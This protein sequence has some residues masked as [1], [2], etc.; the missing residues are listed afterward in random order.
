MENAVFKVQAAVQTSDEPLT[1]QWQV[2]KDNGTTWT[3]IPLNDGT[4]ANDGSVGSDTCMLIVSTSIYDDGDQFR[5]IVSKELNGTPYEITSQAGTL[6]IG[7]VPGVPTG[8]IYGAHLSIVTHPADLL[9][10]EGATA[11]FSVL[12][13]SSTIPTYQW[14]VSVDNGITY[15]VIPGETG[16]EYTFTTAAGDSGNLYR[17]QVSLGDAS[18]FT[19]PAELTLFAPLWTITVKVDVDDVPATFTG[20]GGF[21]YP[22]GEITVKDGSDQTFYITPRY[23][24]WLSALTVDGADVYQFGMTEYTMENIDDDHEL[25]ATFSPG[26]YIHLEFVGTGYGEVTYEIETYS[27]SA[28]IDDTYSIIVPFG[29]SVILTQTPTN[30]GVFVSWTGEEDSLD[31]SITLSSLTNAD[32]YETVTFAAPDSTWQLTL[33]PGTGATA[34]VSFGGK[35]FTYIGK[36]ANIPNGTS[37]IVELTV[38]SPGKSFLYWEGTENYVTEEFTANPSPC[39]DEDRSYTAVYEDMS[40]VVT[41]TIEWPVNGMIELTVNGLTISNIPFGDPF[42]VSVNHTVE[43]SAVPD[44]GYSFVAWKCTQLGHTGNNPWSFSLTEDT[45]VDSMFMLDGDVYELILTATA[46]GS[47]SYVYSYATF[48][49]ITGS[50]GVGG[51]ITLNIPID[52][53]VTVEATPSAGYVFTYWSGIVPDGFD[54]DSGDDQTFNMEDP[55]DM[56]ANFV[57]I[58][59]P[60]A[61]KNYLITATADSRTTINP[62]GNVT[63]SHG[64]DKTF[65]FSAEEGYHVNRV[66]VDGVEISQAA[67]ERGYYTFLS[68]VA[69][70]TIEVYSASGPRLTLTLW[71]DV[72][73]GKGGAQYSVNGG[74][75][76]AYVGP[77][78]LNWNS[79]VTLVAY[80]DTGYQFKE[81][82]DG[83][84]VI[85]TSEYTLYNLTGTSKEVELYFSSTGGS[86]GGNSLLLWIAAVLLLLILAGLLIWFLFFYRRTVEVIKVAYSATIIGKDRV[87]RKKAYPFT[88]EGES[89]TVSYRIGEDGGWKML[90]PDAEGNY[91]IPKGEITETV[92]IECR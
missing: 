24:F 87:R 31:D 37:A 21:V 25:I 33:A 70:H 68:V 1:Y 2:S 15:S 54:I 30:G 41:L 34:V 19:M 66:I 76:Q 91:L 35:T 58:P 29:E 6:N 39:S 92:T 36:P 90:Q 23:G 28:T 57:R 50:T 16:F 5:C 73:E 3:N 11:T 86:D 4:A 32:I 75:F 51:S 55:Y 72:T 18:V 84:S 22:G 49:N 42:N 81:W 13:C 60:M 80:A 10:E 64:S 53:E 78:T 26:Y 44:L 77:T 46:G 52:F 14:Q 8:W 61:D 9:C 89:G 63:V 62:K 27:F 65:Y 56:T 59:R 88:I 48:G 7:A 79:N 74:S 20:T 17:C 47:A 67:V 83:S 69:N 71:V 43:L 40:D 12:A 85:T 82:T 45:T 38:F